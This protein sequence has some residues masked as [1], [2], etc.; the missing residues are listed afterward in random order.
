MFKRYADYDLGA[1]FV[2]LENDQYAPATAQ[3]CLDTQTRFGLTMP[4]VINPGGDLPD[5]LGMPVGAVDVVT[6][7]GH[8][9]TKEEYLN[10][11]DARAAIDSAFGL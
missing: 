11:D 4:V 6:R 8:V 7:C 9:T 1:F 2:V 5:A 3:D 10:D